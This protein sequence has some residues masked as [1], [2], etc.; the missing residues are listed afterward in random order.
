MKFRAKINMKK[1][2]DDKIKE[3]V[4]G[5]IAI[6]NKCEWGV[7]DDYVLYGF[8]DDELDKAF[9][10]ELEQDDFFGVYKDYDEFSKDYDNGDYD[11]SCCIVIKETDFERV[12][13]EN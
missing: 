6:L 12:E 7:A 5:N 13:E 2:D 1:C 8:E 9:W 11:T 10:W 4:N 3:L